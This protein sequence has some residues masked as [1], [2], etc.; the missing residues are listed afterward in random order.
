M[1]EN[2]LQDENQNIIF[3]K[4]QSLFGNK[5]HRIL[6]IQPLPLNTEYLEINQVKNRRYYA[7]PPY[8]LG[9]LCENIKN[10][11]YEV[12]ILDL[13][14]EVLSHIN[15]NAENYDDTLAQHEAEKIWKEKTAEI[16][17][18]FKPDMVALTCMFT[19]GHEMLVRMS[20][21]IRD[22]RPNIPIF[23]GGVHITNA[24][25]YILREAKNIDFVG[26]YEGDISFCD[27]ID[28]VNDRSSIENLKQI[29]TI[30]NDQYLTCDQRNPPQPEDLNVIPDFDDLPL[31]L[32]STL[33]E[34]GS[35]RS[36]LPVDFRASSVLSNRGCRASCSFCSV[37]NFN[38]KSVRTRDVD[39]VVDEI[40]YLNK[41][42]G[43]THI[44][45]ID[46]DLFYNQR[47]T[48]ELFNEI[49]DRQ[50]DITWC[51]SNGVIASVAVKTPELMAA[52]ARSG[53]I[54][55]TFGLESGSDEILKE[56]RKPSRVVHYHKVGE[57]MKK[58]PQ[59]F[60][61]GFL[62]IGFPNETLEQ[63][64]ET[65]KMA[66]EIELDWY[67]V[68][69]L[70]PLPSTRIYDTMVELGLIDDIRVKKN[71][72]D[73]DSK[74]FVVRHGENQRAKEKA[75][76]AAAPKFLNPFETED[77]NIVPS[78]EALH[79]IWL[80]VDYWINYEP[81]LKMTDLNRL[82]KKRAILFDICNRMTKDNPIANLFLGIV[83]EKLGNNTEAAAHRTLAVE[84]LSQSD[85]WQKQFQAL[86]IY[87]LI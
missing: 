61:R 55:M 9:V 74:L 45:W 7:W 28:V 58:Y 21:F 54:G 72:D 68:Q 69:L 83:E 76:K 11:G 70:S 66:Q 12:K 32:Y 82:K 13:N 6:L 84:Y 44:V 64:L 30:I 51:A 67:G 22:Q 36:W 39:S 52:A 17:D 65:V 87:N 26:L 73:A 27:M 10:R 19:M 38:G 34:V 35:Y 15:N 85:Y 29:S 8:G 20:D 48:I 62:I 60:T 56:V 18:D 24:P 4:L 1:N 16:I 78:R 47:R 41:N 5:C 14:Y 23:A 40:E 71:K 86:K 3:N 25:E 79:D 2:A 75:Q 57:T 59:I 80:L 77:L 50:I 63:M 33:G 43:I 46:D 31:G 81:I 42:H 53:C 37:L 49:A